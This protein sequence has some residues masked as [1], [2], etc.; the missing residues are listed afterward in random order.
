MRSTPLDTTA[1]K[2]VFWSALL[3]SALELYWLVQ[4]HS[5]SDAATNHAISTAR[6]VEYSI[7]PVGPFADDLRAMLESKGNEGWE[8]AAPVVSN[9]TTTALIFERERK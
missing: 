1:K 3:L 5:T 9:G 2:L 6:K 4:R 7:V 8:L